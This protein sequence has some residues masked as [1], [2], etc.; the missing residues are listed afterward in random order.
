[1]ANSNEL[2]PRNPFVPEVTDSNGKYIVGPEIDSVLKR[3]V[4]MAQLANLA[5]I[6]ISLENAKFQGKLDPRNLSVTPTP[7]FIDLLNNHPNTPWIEADFVNRGNVTM[8]V[9]INVEDKFIPIGP[10]EKFFFD[11][12]QANQKIEGIYYYCSPGGTTTMQVLGKY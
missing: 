5:R 12:K 8:Y 7:K 1:M 3:V 11:V 4:D 9:S 2:I 10:G 6:R